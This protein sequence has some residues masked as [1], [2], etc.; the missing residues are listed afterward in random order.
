MLKQLKYYIL[1]SVIC[2]TS[3]YA[4][5]LRN[6]VEDTLNS[7]PSIIAE[8]LNRDAYELYIHQEEADY[9]PTLNLDAYLEKSKTYDDP[10]TPPPA[11]GWTKKNG[12]NAVLKLE[13]VLYDGGLTPSQAQEFRYRYN[14]NKYR[15]L[16]S[17]ENIILDTVNAYLDLTSRQELVALS[18]HNIKLH[19]NY[20]TIAKEKEEISGEVLETHQV[21]SKYHSVLDRYLEQE[22]EQK[23]A[24]SLYKKLVGKDLKG[25]ICRPNVNESFLPPSLEEAIKVGVRRSYKVQE[26]I[27]KTKE[28]KEKIIQE[29]AGFKPTIKVQLQ[30]L[31]DNDIELAENGR[32]DIYSARLYLSWNLFE[33]GKTYY[34]TQKEKLFL[35]EEQKK[36]DAV[37]NEVIDEIKESYNTF[38]NLQKRIENMKL[39]VEDNF[40]IVKVYKKQ[41]ADGTRTFIDILNAE[42]ELY[43]SNIDKIQQ[44][45]DY[46][47]AYYNLLFNMSILSDVIL[48]QEKQTCDKYAFVPRD[49]EPKVDPTDTGLSEDLLNMFDETPTSQDET[50]IEEKSPIK[51]EMDVDSMI[52]NI[53]NNE[54]SDEKPKSNV[55]TLS[56]GSDDSNK[57]KYTIKIAIFKAEKDLKE[58]VKNHKLMDNYNFHKVGKNN[59]ILQLTYGNY[60]SVADAKEAIK[61][62][63]RKA[64]VYGAYIDNINK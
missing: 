61:A 14:S 21:N 22:N 1:L 53:Y 51:E 34:M 27:E 48:M 47:S 19:E 13:H 59:N 46:I 20:L 38:Y 2:T 25:N 11:Q 23:Q 49:T 54:K 3:I 6:S 5:S 35:Q 18:Q 43:R 56:L 40:N 17:V 16:Y 41:L 36:L 58:F 9:L 37:T 30:T 50:P 4:T 32:E 12:W 26:Q 63:N 8:H 42:A 10:D 28:Q 31:L 15:S 55:E 7:N 57:Y 60:V 24:L 29:K 52:E 33:G 45:F 39:Y 62:I 64:L 44:D